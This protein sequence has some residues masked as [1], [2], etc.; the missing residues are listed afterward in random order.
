MKK[1]DAR[2]LST[3][4]QQHN[5]QNAVR[6]YTEGRSQ[7]DIASLLGVHFRTVNTW[8]AAFKKGGMDAVAIKKRGRAA[9]SKR[10]LT[11]AQE[12]ALK[13]KLVDASPHQMKLD[14]ALWTSKAI[15]ALV[16]DMWRV[17][18]APRTLR[19]YMRRWGFT[20]QKPVLRAYER[21]PEKVQRWLDTD[22][23]AIQAKAKAHGAAIFWA[24]ETGVCNEPQHGRGYA[25]KGKTP[26][27]EHSTKRYRIN[28]I[29][30]L[31]NRGKVRFMLY[32]ESMTARVL[33]RFF[34][35]L[36]KDV[37]RKVFVILDNLRVHHAKLVRQWAA[38]HCDAIEL[39]YLPAYS[40]DLNPD[41][42]L[43]GDLKSRLRNSTPARNEKELL[44]TVRSHMRILQKNPDRV[45]RYFNHP[46]IQYAA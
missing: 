43:N 1:I 36:I 37:K 14:F 22:Y 10:K 44:S 39:Y 33:L 30:A 26:V 24:D 45:R 34:K 2:K 46:K 3:E 17:Q 27:L 16:W 9:G 15:R 35:R 13:Q 28:M 42:Y 29:S 18:I 11:Q 12:V 40:P 5:R 32:K 20:P 41:E 19:T 38:R 6:L 4:I 23:P 21:N 7:R 25:P 8:I 31:D